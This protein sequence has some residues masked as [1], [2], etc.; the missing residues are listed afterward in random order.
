MSLETLVSRTA[1]L[2]RAMQA[3]MKD[4]EHYGTIPGCGEKPTLF[5]AGAE[6]LAFLFRLAPNFSV[7]VIELAGGHREYRVQCTM[8]SP[9]GMA[10]GQGL[11]SA[12]T[13]ESKWRYRSENTGKVVP[14][15]F[16]AGRDRLMLG[17]PDYFERKVKDKNGNPVWLIF[18]RIEVADIADVY[19]T[20]LKMAAKRAQV[21][22][23]LT[24]TGASDLFSQDLEDLEHQEAEAAA[25]EAEAPAAKESKVADRMK[26]QR[27]AD[28]HGSGVSA[29][30]AGEPAAPTTPKNGQ[31]VDWDK[32][33]PDSVIL[34]VDRLI[35][36]SG[37]TK[38][39]AD[40]W[41][42]KRHGGKIDSLPVADLRPLCKIPYKWL[43][44][45]KQFAGA[46]PAGNR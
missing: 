26:A 9:D 38:A 2:Q 13:M 16:W 46:V 6:K 20:V 28:P 33:S 32:A 19:N 11:G 37:L 8:C 42:M 40:S 25:V 22:A 29:P 30:V 44:E 39:Q 10:L 34:E 15:E 12:C 17:G 1:L 45:V 27:Q 41:A 31:E 36:D 43:A 21:A 4:K 3:V 23:T 24:V 18:H 7:E 5:K 35:V 14:K